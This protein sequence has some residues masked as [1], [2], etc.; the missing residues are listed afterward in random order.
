MGNGIALVVADT[1]QVQDIIVVQ[2]SNQDM[3]MVLDSY[4]M[5][6]GCTGES[7]HRWLSDPPTCGSRICELHCCEVVVGQFWF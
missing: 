2:E 1:A 3:I 4:Y 6:V 7:G 5:L